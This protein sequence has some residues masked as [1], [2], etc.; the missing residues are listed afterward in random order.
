MAQLD[1]LEDR[2]VLSFRE[3][4]KNFDH[5]RMLWSMGSAVIPCN[6]RIRLTARSAAEIIEELREIR[7]AER[8]G[9][10]RDGGRGMG[11]LNK[12]G[13]LHGEPCS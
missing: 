1:E 13:Y 10:A 7:V 2:S 12:N 6:A 8:E 5:L 11:K 3:G 4:Y 9:R